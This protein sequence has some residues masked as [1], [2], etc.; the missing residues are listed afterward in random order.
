MAILTMDVFPSLTA[1]ASDGPS[2]WEVVKRTVVWLSMVAIGSV[3]V[4][5]TRSEQVGRVSRGLADNPIGALIL[6]FGVQLALLPL[7]LLMSAALALTIVGIL[8]IPFAVLAI[9]LLAA[10]LGVFG[11]VGALHMWGRGTRGANTTAMTARGAELQSL[12]TGL[13]TLALPW[14]V[15]AMVR[16][17][18]GLLSGIVTVLA[19]VVTWLFV[20]AGMGAAIR[21]RLG[22]YEHDAPWGIRRSMPGATPLPVKEVQPQWMTPTPIQGVVAAKR[23]TETSS[24]R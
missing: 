6:G 8:A 15:A 12:I 16:P 22:L 24:A 2:T 11:L 4:I 23:P 17:F 3:F 20:T 21:T 1:L 18:S 13:I 14:I 5:T 9:V 10:G 7:T 19:S